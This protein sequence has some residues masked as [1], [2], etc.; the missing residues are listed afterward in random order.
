M[1]I[2]GDTIICELSQSTTRVVKF[3]SRDLVAFLTVMA[4]KTFGKK[5]RTWPAPNRKF[6]EGPCPGVP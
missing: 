4:A 6:E 5:P 1:A 2:C 3:F